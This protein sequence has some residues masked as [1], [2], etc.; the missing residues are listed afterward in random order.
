[1]T[2]PSTEDII[3]EAIEV[4]RILGPGLL[5]DIY[6]TCLCHR[7]AKAGMPVRRKVRIPLV[8]D[9]IRFAQSYVA[10]IIVADT[11]VLEIK[12]V[13]RLLPVHTAQLRT[14]LRLSGCR[15]GL[16]LNFNEILLKRGLRRVDL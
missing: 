6:D 9:G 1:M 5:E 2:E 14:Y 8:F 10:D 7:L 13:E 16:L 4:H 12:S 15:V 11:I 3:H